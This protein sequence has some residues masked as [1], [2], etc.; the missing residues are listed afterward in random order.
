MKRLPFSL[1]MVRAFR[2][3]FKTQTRRVSPPRFEVGETVAIAEPCTVRLD[4]GEYSIVRCYYAADD[5]VCI[6]D[7]RAERERCATMTTVQNATP[8][9]AR[10][11]PGWAERSR[12][13][14][15]EIREE[16]LG[17]ITEADA[18]REGFANVAEF[19]AYFA[20]IDDRVPVDRL[21][22]LADLNLPVWVVSFEVVT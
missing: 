16:R 7:D 19:M 4:P 2:D 5:A 11:M 21:R 14:I 17:D 6:L 15:T 3:G 9:S 22:T 10:F 12:V 1:P 13:R 20:S 18:V 8:R